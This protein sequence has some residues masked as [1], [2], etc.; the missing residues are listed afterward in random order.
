[1]IGNDIVDL[2]LA[3]K[4][5]NW[6]RP[7]FLDKIFTLKEQKY[8]LKSQEPE[9]M[10]WLL[11]SMKESAYKLHVQVYGK[12]FF[13]P[14]RF[15]STIIDLGQKESFGE[16]ICDDYQCF[17]QSEISNQ[18]VHTISKLDKKDYFFSETFTVR[19]AN[20][21]THSDSVYK[22]V[23]AQFTKFSGK[24]IHSISIKK[25]VK[26]IPFFYFKNEKM[27]TALSMTHHGNFGAFAI[28]NF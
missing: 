8:I 5:S 13:A 21:R 25:N 19:N 27:N 14:K 26:G 24:A 28:K 2:A 11:W 3:K 17:T 15:A 10:V 20:Y 6:N 7:R 1:M 9:K 12:R 18:F 22:K 23:I 4:K 16:V